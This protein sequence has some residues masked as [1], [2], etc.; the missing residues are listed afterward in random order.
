MTTLFYR[1]WV[2]L[3]AETTHLEQVLAKDVATG[4]TW[5]AGVIEHTEST[6]VAK[7]RE[8]AATLGM[9]IYKLTV[10]SPSTVDNADE[11]VP[12]TV[13]APAPAPAPVAVPSPAAAG[14]PHPGVN[15]GRP[16]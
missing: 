16:L 4:K 12:G 8:E 5:I 9:G 6:A 14:A 1:T 3:K 2:K 13:T 7:L 11:A 15:G 10:G